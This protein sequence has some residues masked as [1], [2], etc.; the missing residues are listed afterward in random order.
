M[1]LPSPVRA[2]TGN[3]PLQ[4]EALVG[5]VRWRGRIDSDERIEVALAATGRPTSIAVV[6]RLLVGGV[7]DY[8]LAV[9][10][11][12][13]DVQP[14]PGS[15]ADPG[16]R[17]GAVLWQGFSPG[18][19][20][21]AAR[22]ELMPA[23]AAPFLPVRVRVTRDGTSVQVRIENA[24]AY[25]VDLPA[26]VGRPAELRA[27]LAAVRGGSV[28][29]VFAHLAR[30]PGS[31]TVRIEAPL[32]VTGEVRV[33]SA[34]APV[35]ALLGAGRPLVQTVT[36][37]GSGVPRVMLVVRPELPGR[38]YVLPPGLDGAQAL[39]RTAETLARSARVHQY[40]LFLANPDAKG[41]ADAV[42]VFRTAAA[43]PAVA[44][45][46][47]AADDGL[48]T[49]GYLLLGLGAAVALAGGAVLW[50]RS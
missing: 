47:P 21:L 30:P 16:L 12:I 9:P 48:G 14:A 10:G 49:L 7:G 38:L 40:R 34:R 13:A 46:A 15:D 4:S 27:I 17:S 29:D 44:S 28:G 32:R 23:R 3:P 2:P 45:S 20:R 25:A 24:T 8:V 22:I 6:Q 36:L 50:S 33:G 18:G 35:A 11:P 31:R 5:E 26:G 1:L 43:R 19:E 39:N 41:R 42:Y 37:N